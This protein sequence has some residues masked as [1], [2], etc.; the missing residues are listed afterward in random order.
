MCDV[1]AYA[2]IAQGIAG[3]Y[4]QNQ[5]YRANR[6][7]A[8]QAHEDATAGLAE[9]R[10]QLQAKNTDEMVERSRQATLE[11][12]F[13]EAM[14]ADSGLTGNT[15]AR[16]AAVSAGN[17][18]RDLTTMERNGAARTNQSHQ[19]QAEIDA[20][21]RAQTNSVQRP[22]FVGTALQIGVAGAEARQRK[23]RQG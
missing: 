3:A 15:Q 2:Q 21:R 13:I 18:E 9:Q 10:W 20:R 14:F 8:D 17:A 22:S 23:T 5:R 19:Q 16:I 1:V 7:A 12:G 4:G 6:S 11:Q